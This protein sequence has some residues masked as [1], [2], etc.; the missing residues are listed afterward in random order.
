MKFNNAPPLLRK[1][2]VLIIVTAFLVAFAQFSPAAAGDDDPAYGAQ[3][4][5]YSCFMKALGNMTQGDLKE[6]GELSTLLSKKSLADDEA[7]RLNAYGRAIYEKYKAEI[8]ALIKDYDKIA[9]SKNPVPS[10]A[11]YAA[12][13]VADK[14]IDFGYTRSLARSMIAVARYLHSEKRHEEALKLS[15][16][17]WR[18]G[19]MISSGDGGVPS[20]IMSMIGIAVKNIAA[21]GNFTR[22]LT[23]GNFSAEFYDDFSAVLLKTSEDE[24]DMKA[25]MNSERR[26]MINVFE[27]EVFIKNNKDPQYSN[28]LGRLSDSM[29]DESKKY[30]IGLFN[31]YYDSLSV[32]LT[33][34]A[35]E[36]YVIKGLVEKQAA[37]I[38]KNGQ[39]TAWNFFNPSRAV[40]NILLAI[41][42]PNSSRAYDHF[43]RAKLYPYGAAVLSKIL[44]GVKKGAIVPRTIAEIEEA[45]GFKL[46]PDWFNDKKGPLVYKPAG[47]NFVLYSF[48]LNY[49]DDNASEKDDIILFTIPKS[50]K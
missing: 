31:D 10:E 18:F 7:S 15:F 38:S 49:A 2:F 19:Q 21:E 4:R 25:V 9:G 24:M 46:P 37:E 45:C 44:S 5:P 12:A 40:G 42:I 6:I 13:R 36:P 17:V 29:L 27:Y 11:Q 48:G 16:I 22:G 32:W 39:P 50:Y 30:T 28:L 8:D 33:D 1:S 41:A 26:I 20:L 34:H 43:L 3:R 47:D 14:T 23:V 35:A